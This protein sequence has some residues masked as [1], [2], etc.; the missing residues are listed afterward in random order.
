[1]QA[2]A[3]AVRRLLA[4]GA[5]PGDERL[6]QRAGTLHDLAQKVPAL[7]PA[8]SAAERVTASDADTAP[9]ALLD[10]LA[11]LRLLGDRV[12]QQWA[13]AEALALVGPHAPAA[14]VPGVVEAL[15]KEEAPLTRP[16]MMEVLK[17]IGPPAREA[18]LSLSLFAESGAD[19]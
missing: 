9:G 14:V 17:R 13:A 15:L 18:T 10:L 7:A 12:A 6:R 8:A 19:R 2:L 1:L 4:A 11:L 16:R 3:A 5:A